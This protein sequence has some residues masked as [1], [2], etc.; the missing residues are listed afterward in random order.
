MW[1]ETILGRPEGRP[2]FYYH[3]GKSAPSFSRRTARGRMKYPWEICRFEAGRWKGKG[4]EE[5]SL[6]LAGFTEMEK[7]T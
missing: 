7:P 5:R 6:R 3:T 2:F 1:S 4:C